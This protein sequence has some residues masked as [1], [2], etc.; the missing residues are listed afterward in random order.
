[1]SLPTGFRRLSDV[2]KKAVKQTY[3]DL[4]AWIGKT[5]RLDAVNIQSEKDGDKTVL[6]GG[7]M[8]FSEFDPADPDKE[9]S[10]E[11][12]TTSQIPRGAIRV[13]FDALS[14][15]PDETIICDVVQ[16]KRGIALQ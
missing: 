11:N 13:L 8:K 5:I 7:V 2:R 1:M 16:T 10:D 15:N 4:T 14:K 12:L 6:K 9:V 3:G